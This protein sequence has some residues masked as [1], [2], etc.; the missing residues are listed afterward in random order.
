MNYYPHHIGDFNSSTRFS[1]RLDRSIY[2]DMLDV[3]Y[4]TEKPLPLEMSVLI[5]KIAGKK[6]TEEEVTAINDI[7]AEFFT[8][9]DEGWVNDR[10]QREIA[11]YHEGLEKS[12]AG[13][14]A[15]AKKR[16]DAAKL[17]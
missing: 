9:T 4:D 7:L 2:R 16:A 3:Y 13:G 6:A 10:C 15:L 12:S 17:V 1:S 11:A 5:K 8:R 14:K